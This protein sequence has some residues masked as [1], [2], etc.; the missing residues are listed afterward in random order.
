MVTMNSV[1]YLLAL[2]FFGIL[3]FTLAKLLSSILK[4]CLVSVGIFV[5][6]FGTYVF[7]KSTK[8]PVVLFHSILIDNFDVTYLGA[9][10]R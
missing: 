9:W 7:L 2:I 6:V 8:E 5:I 10:P 3:Y 4:G 1:Y